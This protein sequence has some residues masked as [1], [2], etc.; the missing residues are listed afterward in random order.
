M[1]LCLYDS[2]F[3]NINS[4]VSH[5]FL[6]YH[7]GPVLLINLI[8]KITGDRTRLRKMKPYY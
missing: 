8:L 1:F 3:S 5:L 6:K 4:A 7:M 2:Q